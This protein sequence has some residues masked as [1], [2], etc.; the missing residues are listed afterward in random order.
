M[1]FSLFIPT[2]V[3]IFALVITK[4]VTLPETKV[5]QKDETTKTFQ[6]NG[7][8]DMA[9]IEIMTDC[10][11]QRA[12]RNKKVIADFKKLNPEIMAKGFK[13][14]RTLSIIAKR[15]NMTPAGV[16]FVLTKAGEFEKL[17]D[18]TLRQK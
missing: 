6:K 15:Y 5:K 12:E 14:Y 18:L 7:G 11:K 13:P 17:T 10:E 4:R 2:F 1:V 9:N 3:V 16:R 8:N